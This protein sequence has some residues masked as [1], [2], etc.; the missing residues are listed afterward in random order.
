MTPTETDKVH[1]II[2]PSFLHIGLHCSM[3]VGLKEKLPPR[4][5][6]E[7]AKKGNR[8]HEGAAT[9]LRNSL[10]QRVDGV[11]KYYDL[12]IEAD[13]KEIAEA[14]V[15][16]VWEKI[17]GK[18]ITGKAWG[19]EEKLIYSTKLSLWGTT[20]LWVIS[21]DERAKRY[22][23]IADLKT[24][25]IPVE[26][27]DNPQL[28]AY[29]VFL[30]KMVRDAGKDLD[31][32]RAA[33]FQPFSQG[34]K[35][36]ET[37]FTDK[38]LDRFE[39]KL[40]KLA[41][42]VFSGTAKYKVGNHCQYCPVQLD[43]DL[44]KK[45]LDQK[46]SLKLLQPEAIVFPDIEKLPDG[47]L[48]NLILHE[49]KLATLIKHAKTRVRER[50]AEGE[51]IPGIK[52]VEGQARRKMDDT[53]TTDIEEAL[54]VYNVSPYVPK[55]RGIGELETE[56]KAYIKPKAAKELIDKFTTRGPNPISLVP[57][58]DPRPAV[59]SKVALLQN[60][61]TEETYE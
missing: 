2:S 35:W 61:E 47:V 33:I 8:I 37:K 14:F 48:V 22:G 51:T 4:E 20:D 16:V 50:I 57:E 45:T 5:P 18:S 36:K 49:K 21:T 56:L 55:L 54:K 13:E 32:C 58:S 30:R 31:Y 43:C 46:T 52:A 28:L 27:D 42:T 7:A 29:C 40:L 44:Y 38:Q 6:N 41:E 26:A 11:D 59:V 60:L 34:E 24:G 15:L 12:Q 39:Q 17:F 3:A 1:A 23:F 9:I 19:I 25:H 10:Q 53:K